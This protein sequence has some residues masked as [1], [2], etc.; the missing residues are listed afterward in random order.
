MTAFDRLVGRA[1]GRPF[2]RP[3]TARLAIPAL[4][5]VVVGQRAFR[6]VDGRVVPVGW[7]DNMPDDPEFGRLEGKPF[8]RFIEFVRRVSILD[9]GPED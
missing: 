5:A 8:E 1:V 2:R 4:G 7:P 3:A 9:L 6:E